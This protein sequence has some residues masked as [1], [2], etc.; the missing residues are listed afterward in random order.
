MADDP[1]PVAIPWYK[2]KI[3][4]GV[5]TGIVAQVISRLQNQYHID[6]TVY[7]VTANDLVSGIMDLITVAAIGWTTRARVTQTTAPQIVASKST[8][9]SINQEAKK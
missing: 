5:V 2:S 9:D 6:L 1:A 7:G 4:Q 8:A 3:L